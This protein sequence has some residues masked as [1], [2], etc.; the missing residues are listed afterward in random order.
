MPVMEPPRNATCSAALRPL[1]AACGAQIRANGNVHADEAGSTREYR[2]NHEAD[3]G[4]HIKRDSQDDRQD[5]AHDGNRLVLAIQIGRR[6]LLDGEGNFP[7]PL[8]AFR[9]AENPAA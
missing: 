6:A 3:G 4:G 8:V 7:H 1:R 9:L 2:A 5:D